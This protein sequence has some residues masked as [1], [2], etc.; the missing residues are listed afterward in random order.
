M[1]PSIDT[2]VN[3][4]GKLT[5]FPDI[6]FRIDEMLCDERS[7][8][9]DITNV[10]EKDP[11]VSAALLRV[12]NSAAYPGMAAVDCIERA[13]QRVGGRELRE[14]TF[15]LCAAS[16]FSRIPNDLIGV[17]DFWLHCLNTAFIAQ[18]LAEGT[19]DLR[20]KS[21]FT[22][23]LLHDIGQLVMFNQCPEAS[24]AALRLSVE[25]T[26]GQEPWLAE[27]KIF[28]FDHADVGL[29]L[30]EAW[31]FPDS[32]KSAIA[33]HH[34]PSG[35]SEHQCIADVI[36]VANAAAV[37]I[38]LESNDLSD[39]P[40]IEPSS[41]Q[42]TGIDETGLIEALRSAKMDSASLL[43]IFAGTSEAA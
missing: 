42:R 36:H 20:G 2:L 25:Q 14:L 7:S 32:I 5:S 19:P 31:N 15:A 28:G 24:V 38:E 12:A 8:L 16:S 39:A 30:A 33:H 10:I 23:A 6:A 27:Q 37:M 11:A 41:L 9:T 26:D 21:V 40:P 17:G 22:P 35:A 3:N 18:H 43:E 29:A 1:I 13:V 34:N 4:I